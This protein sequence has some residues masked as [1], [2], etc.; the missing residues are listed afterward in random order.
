M[1]LLFTLEAVALGV[2]SH[3]FS[4]S[5]LLHVCMP[6]A[7]ALSILSLSSVGEVSVTI[8]SLGSKQGLKVLLRL[9]ER[10]KRVF[11]KRGTVRTNSCVQEG[12]E[13]SGDDLEGTKGTGKK[14]IR[15]GR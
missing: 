1:A 8:R 12:F 15:T 3:L 13:A 4:L 9:A 2:H 14:V 7:L 10:P 5:S 11:T 6:S